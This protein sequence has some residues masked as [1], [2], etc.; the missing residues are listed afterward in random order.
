MIIKSKTR[1]ERLEKP[2]CEIDE[3]LLVYW[4]KEKISIDKNYH[5]WP[6]RSLIWKNSDGVNRK[7]E[8]SLENN[9]KTFQVIGYAWYDNLE[10]HR[11]IKII[12]IRNKIS[13]PLNSILR[14]DI[15]NWI[16]LIN[17]IKKEDLA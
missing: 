10:K 12:T 2:L 17:G 14:E 8:I 5:N 6:S 13:P 4:K 16:N 11:F 3:L 1:W 9:L 7:L 15:Y